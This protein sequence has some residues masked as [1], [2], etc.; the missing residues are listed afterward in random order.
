MGDQVNCFAASVVIEK[1][2]QLLSPLLHSGGHAQPR[3]EHSIAG[4]L[5]AAA[6]AAEILNIDESAEPNTV[7]T[8]QA[9]HQDDRRLELRN[10][11]KSERTTE[12]QRSQRKEHRVE[13]SSIT[14]KK[15]TL[16]HRI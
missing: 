2:L 13:R 16:A 14:A 10:E 4:F 8:E 11:H 7:V 15:S 9:V 6:D 5:E 12:S 3:H 1:L